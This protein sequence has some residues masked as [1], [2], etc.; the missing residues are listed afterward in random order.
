MHVDTA[1]TAEGETLRVHVCLLARDRSI[2]LQLDARIRRVGG[3]LKIEAA[4]WARH[5]ELGLT[6]SPLGMI[7]SDSELRVVGYLIPATEASATSI[8]DGAVTSTP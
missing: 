5:R 8:L 7:P 4:T 3:E 1:C 6:R 2:P